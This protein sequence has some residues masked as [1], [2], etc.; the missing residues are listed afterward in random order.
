MIVLLGLVLTGWMGTAGGATTQAQASASPCADTLDTA[1]QAYRNRS[2]EEAIALASSCTDSEAVGQETAIRAYRLITLA[3]LRQGAL[4]QA[5]S[6]VTDLLKIDPDYTPDPVND[7][8]AYDLFVSM[9]RRD[10]PPE[11]T[12]ETQADTTSTDGEAADI[13]P[14]ETEVASRA[15]RGLFLKFGGGISDYTGD[16][17]AQN[18]GHPLDFQE[19]ITGSGVPLMASVE[20][21]YQVSSGWAVVAGFQFGNYPIV[22]YK[23]PTINDSYRYTPQL[24]IRYTFRA[25]TR[26]VRPY[27]DLGGNATFGGERF[28]STGAGPSVGGGLNIAV[29]RTTSFYIESRFNL[30]LPDDAIDGFASEG[31]GFNGSILNPVDSV[32]QLLGMGLRIKFGR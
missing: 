17:P 2:Y 9:V 8:P 14:P 27:I 4:V 23:K 18:V 22:G 24:L 10:T 32:N 15:H 7:P 12:A 11:A 29:G 19:F 3:S 30:T 13:P 16:Y 25:P 26:T 5:R 31:G 20:L 28:T 6:A 21:G 1:E